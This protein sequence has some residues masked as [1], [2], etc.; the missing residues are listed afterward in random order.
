[1]EMVRRKTR[2]LRQ[3]LQRQLLVQMIL[4]IQK[5][6]E[7]PLLVRCLCIFFHAGHD[8]RKAKLILDI[9]CGF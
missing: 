2:D 9:F 4:D 8:T 7:N 1:M 5:H 6:L 3:F